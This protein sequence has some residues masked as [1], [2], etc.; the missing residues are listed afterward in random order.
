MVRGN[1]KKI[2][3]ENIYLHL[4]LYTQL[5]YWCINSIQNIRNEDIFNIIS[6]EISKFEVG[7]ASVVPLVW[8]N[9][10]KVKLVLVI[11]HGELRNF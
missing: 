10:I 11:V 5:R 8:L 3:N 6:R 7:R 1:K 4:I 2:Q 9:T